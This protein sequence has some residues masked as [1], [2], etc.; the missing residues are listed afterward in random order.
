MFP[1]TLRSIPAPPSGGDGRAQRLSPTD[2]TV[3]P[4]AEVL[5]D[6]CHRQAQFGAGDQTGAPEPVLDRRR[7]RLCEEQSRQV[8]DRAPG[9]QCGDTFAGESYV[10]FGKPDGTPVDLANLGAGGFRIDGIDP[11]DRSGGSVSGAGAR[12]RLST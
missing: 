12:W 10:V 5:R 8:T 7:A 4:C 3:D 1:S 11:L 2:F 6:R 9:S